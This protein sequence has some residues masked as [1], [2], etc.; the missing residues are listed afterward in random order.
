MGAETANLQ[1]ESVV[2]IGIHSDCGRGDG[3]HH[4]H[5]D[6]RGQRAVLAY[7]RGFDQQAQEKLAAA[8]AS[9]RSTTAGSNCMALR[10]A[11]A[12]PAKVMVSAAK[13]IS[14]STTG[15]TSI[16]DPKIL[17]PMVRASAAPAK[18]PVTPPARPSNPASVRNSEATEMLE[19][20]SDFINP[21]SWRRSRIVAA[22]AAE[23]A[24]TE[25]SNAASVSSSISPETRDNTLPWFC[26]TWRTCSTRTL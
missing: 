4:G 7:P 24:S 26:S 12:L 10:T 25:A 21:T 9:P 17:L 14:A 8:H 1:A 23:T 5:S 20:P 22:I 13:R 15:W 11:P 19:A 2:Q 3:C 18:K 6:E 16:D